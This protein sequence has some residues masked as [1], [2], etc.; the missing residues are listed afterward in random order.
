MAEHDI[1]SG[2]IIAIDVETFG[3]TCTLSNEVAPVT[4]EGAQY[5]V[6]FCLGVAATSGASSLLPL[7]EESLANARAIDT[8]QR[9]R[10]TVTPE[11]DTMFPAAV[12]GRVRVTTASGVFERTVLTPKGEP[13]N[14][15]SWEDIDSKFQTISAGRVGA[16]VAGGVRSA[17]GALRTGDVTALKS[18]LEVRIFPE[19][20]CR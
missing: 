17:I 12:P 8:A 14:P 10:M 1:R 5:S 19:P 18:M 6:P 13:A 9:V 11:F 7:G 20:D 15:M 16:G 3:R 2:E 4:L